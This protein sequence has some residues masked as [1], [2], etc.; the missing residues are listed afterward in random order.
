MNSVGKNPLVAS[1]LRSHG[2]GGGYG[3]GDDDDGEGR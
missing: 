2:Y 1:L 3:G